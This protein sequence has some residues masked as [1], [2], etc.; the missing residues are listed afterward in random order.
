[1]TNIEPQETYSIEAIPETSDEALK[2]IKR[3]PRV[4]LQRKKEFY[5]LMDNLAMAGVKIYNGRSIIKGLIDM[6]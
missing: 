1:M 2:E 4:R 6:A 3:N 5:D